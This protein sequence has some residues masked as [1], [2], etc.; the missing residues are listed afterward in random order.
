MIGDF[1]IYIFLEVRERNTINSPHIMQ[2]T[3]LVM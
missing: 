1:Q 3:L 2:K